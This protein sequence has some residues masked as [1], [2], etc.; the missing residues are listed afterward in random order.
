MADPLQ[1]P[2]ISKMEGH[3]QKLCALVINKLAPGGVTITVDDMKAF[4]EN[5]HLLTHGKM[6]GIELK[7]VSPE[8]A[9][10]IHEYNQTQKGSA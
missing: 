10:A 9:A 7:I 1:V 8:Q 3:W 2:I 4:P 6:D 5:H